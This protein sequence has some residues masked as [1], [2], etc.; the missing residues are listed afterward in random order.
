MR[1][2]IYEFVHLDSDDAFLALGRAFGGILQNKTFKFD[3]RVVNGELTKWEPEAGLWIRKWTITVF[4][5]IVLHK[6]PDAVATDK[7]YSLVYLLDPSLFKLKKNAK[8][9]SLNGHHNCLFFSS[10][11]AMDFSVVPKQPF[12]C[13]DI[14]FTS[15]W[16]FRQF[17]DADEGFK[18]VLE[19]YLAKSCKTVLFEPCCIDEYKTLHELET[20]I[21][22]DKEDVLFIRS[23]I[24]SLITDF[25]GNI[26]NHDHPGVIQK[27]VRYKQIMQ[28]E[29]MISADVMKPPKV[30][31]ISKEVNM[32]VSSLLRQFKLIHGK[33]IQEYCVEKK[34]DLAK[35]LLLKNRITVKEIARQFGYKQVSSFIETFTKQH[36]CSPGT[37]KSL[38]E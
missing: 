31:L 24:Y 7:K 16:M 10:D 25:F 18:T 33:S 36:G 6:I 28:A 12:Y 4:Q 14:A 1:E 20:S 21:R 13:L 11:L 19:N 5:D 23:K 37:F 32:S 9:L 26:F 30:E 38:E 27:I 22:S 34:M 35:T 8:N 3:N 17:E 15:S 29:M 2:I